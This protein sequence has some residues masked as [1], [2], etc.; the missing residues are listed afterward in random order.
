MALTQGGGLSRQKT[1]AL[2]G[3]HKTQIYFKPD[4]VADFI[5]DAK[6]HKNSNDMNNVLAIKR[7]KKA[8]QF[9]S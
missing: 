1:K 2:P 4:P 7:S 8:R 6:N 5:Q 9:V 3:M